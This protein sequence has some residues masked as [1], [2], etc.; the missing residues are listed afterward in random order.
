MVHLQRARV[1]PRRPRLRRVR[2]RNVSAS[3]LCSALLLTI[4]RTS[5]FFNKVTIDL[6]A[7]KHPLVITSPGAPSKPYIKSVSVNGK[8][9]AG[10]ILTHA[11]IA[12]GGHIEFEMSETPQAWASATLVS[13][14]DES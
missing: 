14:R 8:K 11:D 4:E 2:H 13:A 9:L 10:P 7:A 1:L 3:L 6:P 12:S 5:P